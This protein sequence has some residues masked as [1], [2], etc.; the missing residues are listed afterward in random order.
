MK[1]RITERAQVWLSGTGV[2]QA[3]QFG[4]AQHP[5]EDPVTVEMMR[6]IRDTPST[7]KDRSVVADLTR[8]EAEHLLDFAEAMADS[9]SF[10]AGWDVDARSDLNSGR[11]LVRQ[12]RKELDR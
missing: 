12:I 7:R 10:D 5:D 4:S 6:K 8:A 1:I 11:A 9:A 3:L 2:W